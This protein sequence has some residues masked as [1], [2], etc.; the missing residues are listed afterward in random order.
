MWKAVTT[1]AS[2]IVQAIG[3][4]MKT[5]T[6][7]LGNARFNGLLDLF[8]S[9]TAGGVVLA[10][11]K[12]LKSVSEPLK[13][14]QDILDGVTSI[15]DGV[16]GCFEA[17]QTQLKAGTLM[18]IAVAIGILAGSIVAISLIDSDKLSASLGAITVL[19]ANLMTSMAIFNKISDSSGKTMKA[20]TA[21]LS[22]SISVSILAGALKKVADLEWEEIGKGLVGIAGLSAI[23]VASAKVMS[24][25]SGQI[26]KGATSL[27]VFAAAVKV[28]ASACKDLSV[29]SWEE[30]GKGLTGV[31][32]LM[33]EIAIFLRAANSVAKL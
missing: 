20:C 17:Y 24:S 3:T 27:V 6:E 5:L 19:F 1:I 7:K 30:L 2:G 16:R 4:M 23:V 29:L 31:G 14:L 12:F 25:G 21:M 9:I 10:I 22:M 11:S 33:G 13:G 15:L 18:K 28:L 32:V 26:V 8:N